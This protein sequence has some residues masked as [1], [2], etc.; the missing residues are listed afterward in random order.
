MVVTGVKR[1]L[2]VILIKLVAEFL[3]DHKYHFIPVERKIKSCIFFICPA[4]MNF[5]TNILF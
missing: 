4:G 2:N 5:C 1:L 3:F